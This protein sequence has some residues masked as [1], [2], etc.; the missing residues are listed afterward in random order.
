MEG[1]A[2]ADRFQNMPPKMRRLAR[3]GTYSSTPVVI[4]GIVLSMFFDFRFIALGVVLVAIVVFVPLG[5]AANTEKQQ[6]SSQKAD[7]QEKP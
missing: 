3:V 7:H 5:I 2:M 4:I 1:N 6:L